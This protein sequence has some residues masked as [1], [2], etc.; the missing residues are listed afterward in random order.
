MGTNDIAVLEYIFENEWS[1]LSK[2]REKTRIG[3]W[4][5]NNI[6]HR[7]KDA[8]LIEERRGDR[9]AREF[10]VTKKGEE[11]IKAAKKLKEVLNEEN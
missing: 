8:S 7:L 9:N 5:L 2:I 4:A 3:Q 11:A 10:K 6:I 1:N